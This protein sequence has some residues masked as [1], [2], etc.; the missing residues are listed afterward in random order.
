MSYLKNVDRRFKNGFR[1][2]TKAK[3]VTSGKN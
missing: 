3:A 2:G 1:S